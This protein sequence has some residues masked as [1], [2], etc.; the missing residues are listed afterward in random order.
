MAG[1]KL[2]TPADLQWSEDGQ[3]YASNFSDC[4]FSADNGLAETRHV[5]LTGNQLA[6][7]WA[8]SADSTSAAPNFFVIGETGFGTGLNFIAAWQLW[9]QSQSRHSSQ[10]TSHHYSHLYFVSAELHPLRKDDLQRAAL[11]W[12]EL[13]DFYVQLLEQYPTLTAGY[14]YLHFGDVTLLLLFG[15]ATDMF[16]DWRTTDHPDFLACN[17]KV[18]AW[19]LDG[20]APAKNPTLWTTALVGTLAQLS[21]PQCTLATFSA[22]GAMRR[23]LE[24]A[25]FVVHKQAGYGRKRDM[26]SAVFTASPAAAEPSLRLQPAFVSSP[27]AAPWYLK[28]QDIYRGN[29]NRHDTRVAIIGAGI[30]GC[31]LAHALAC[32]GVKVHVFDEQDGP[33]TQASGNAQAVLYSKFAADNNDFAQF[34]LAS[35]LYALRFYRRLREQQSSLPIQLC[36]VLQLAWNQDERILQDALGEFFLHHREFAQ[37]LTRSEASAVA[38][39]EVASGGVF[40]PQAGWIHPA[41]VCTYLLSH[42]N[43]S[44]VFKQRITHIHYEQGEWQLSNST[45]TLQR[46]TNLVIASGEQCRQFAQS[47][48][49]PLKLI[50]GQVSHATPTPLSQQLRTVLCGN[51]YI[52]PAHQGQQSFGAT[53]S[54]KTSTPKIRDLAVTVQDHHTNLANLASSSSALAAQWQIDDGISGGR[55]QIRTA[56]P[57]YF[58]LCGPLPHTES[59]LNTYAALRKNANANIPQAGSYHP[60]LYVFAGLGSRGMSY[61]PLCAELLCQQ[62]IAAPLPLPRHLVQQLNPARF[63][64]RDLIKNRA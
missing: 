21:K 29:S 28:Q 1:N 36:G 4:Y 49:L 30:A 2:I 9:Q 56:T 15:D 24:Q 17:A 61:A 42:P 11:L 45:G 22:A 34:N 8:Q 38:G 48:G 32:K 44:T 52:A 53:Y 47:Q 7:R 33:A 60:Q 58:P 64:I 14:H 10:H 23:S 5:F 16:N 18:D 40:F 27:Y 26:V 55:T 35:Y 59:F 57:D 43:I 19:F 25:G 54:S 51:G 31:S 6:E 20:F 3:P 46:Y 13:H 41:A 62:I 39:V 50:R 63:I 12:P 37:V